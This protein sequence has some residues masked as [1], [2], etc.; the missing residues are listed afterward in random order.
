ML[1]GG[2]ELRNHDINDLHCPDRPVPDAWRN[3]DAHSLSQLDDFLVELHFRV[4]AAF[5]DEI[6]LCQ[7]FVVVQFG[8]GLDLRHVD[9]RRVIVN[10]GERPFRGAAGAR[11]SWQLRKVDDLPSGL[12]GIAHAEC[13]G[14]LGYV[15]ISAAGPDSDPI[16]QREP[17]SQR[18]TDNSQ[19][20]LVQTYRIPLPDGCRASETTIP[21]RQKTKDARW[22][23]TDVQK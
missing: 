5:E 10:F 9:R 16:L 15:V 13:F 12:Y 1:V 23:L 8:V 20:N 11:S 14:R 3:S 21:T 19:P 7:P 6:S 17:Y 22:P 4:G 18:S 2:I